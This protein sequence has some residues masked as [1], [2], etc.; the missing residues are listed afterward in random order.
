MREW[1]WR[2][3]TLERA[4]RT[5]G[6]RIGEHYAEVCRG[7]LDELAA[8]AGYGIEG[9]TWYTTPGTGGPPMSHYAAVMVKG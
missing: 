2:S 3:R 8:A 7:M 1:A 4:V 9:W 5:Y 6:N